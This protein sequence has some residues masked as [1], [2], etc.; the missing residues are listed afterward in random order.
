VPGLDIDNQIGI[1][2]TL[3]PILGDGAGVR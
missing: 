3:I 1:R 2:Q